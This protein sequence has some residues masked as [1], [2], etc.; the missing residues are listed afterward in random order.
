MATVREV[1]LG[2]RD[3]KFPS[4]DL[5]ELVD[6]THLM[7]NPTALR[8]ALDRQGYAF[9]PLLYNKYV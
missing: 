1:R 9:R 6:S 8:E 5:Q 4:D 2:T 7:D 3:V